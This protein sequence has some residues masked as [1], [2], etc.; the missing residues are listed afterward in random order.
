MVTAPV[1][2]FDSIIIKKQSINFR[3]GFIENIRLLYK[4]EFF[5][6]SAV[7]F[8]LTLLYGSLS[9]VTFSSAINV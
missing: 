1:F 4:L 8:K 3:S 6:L 2:I 5:L 7:D 9:E